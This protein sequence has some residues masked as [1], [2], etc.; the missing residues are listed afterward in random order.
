VKYFFGFLAVIAAIVVVVL[1][2]INLFRNL[3][4]PLEG[5]SLSTS[6][7]DLKS[8]QAK[9]TVARYSVNGA[10]VAEENYR[11]VHITVSKNVR[12]IEII[13]GYNGTVEKT[14]TF[15]NT[16]SAYNTFVGALVAARFSNRVDTTEVPRFTCVTGNRIF[17]Q[18]QEA[19]EKKVD[20]WST[21][22]GADQGNFDGSVD[23]T[24]TIFRNQIPNYGEF[25]S[26]VNLGA[27]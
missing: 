18:L 7:Y 1:L 26:D 13:K 16:P 8:D 27:R 23:G 4:Q 15:P 12:T 22:C 17:Y 14:A 24:A 19:S 20:T 5:T 2:T 6:V 10:I 3:D 21:T 9:D 11:E 25:T